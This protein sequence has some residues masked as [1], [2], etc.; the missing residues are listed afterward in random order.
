MQIKILFYN[1]KIVNN[2][3]KIYKFIRFLDSQRLLVKFVISLLF[4]K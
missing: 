2:Y 3:F 1:Y 4:S